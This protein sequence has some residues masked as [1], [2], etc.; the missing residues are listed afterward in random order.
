MAPDTAALAKP[1]VEGNG[2]FKAI[3]DLIPEQVRATYTEQQLEGLAEAVDKYRWGRHPTDIRLSIPLLSKRFYFVILAGEE[4]RSKTR[5]STERE[6]FPV[7]TLGNLLFLGGFV[8]AATV[9]GSLLWTLLFV[10]FLGS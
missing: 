10:W 6:N 5:R 2:L 3:V 8:T 7:A 4:R 9:V 1:Q